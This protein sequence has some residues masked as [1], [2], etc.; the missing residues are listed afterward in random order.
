MSE[1][2]EGTRVTIDGLKLRLLPWGYDEGTRWSFRLLTL[3][4]RIKGAAGSDMQSA[5]AIGAMIATATETDFVD[6]RDAA[7]KYT[8]LV[9]DEAGREVFIPL[10][11]D[12][13]L[14]GRTYVTVALMKA[15][16]EAQF[17]DFFARLGE[18][19]AASAQPPKGS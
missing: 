3:A 17:A 6:L 14:R 5:R 12:V 8:E 19:F 9:V 13:H 11:P 10:K 2:T 4:G 7:V 15:H 16:V 18:L 1:L